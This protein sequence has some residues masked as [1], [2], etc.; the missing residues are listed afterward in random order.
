MVMAS[1][2]II[3]FMSR[4]FVYGTGHLER[5]IVQFVAFALLSFAAYFLVFERIRNES[6]DALRKSR[7]IYWIIF[8]SIACRFIYWPSQFIQ[9]TDPYRYVWDGQTVLRG[10]NPFQHSPEEA[11]NLKVVPAQQ[12]SNQGKQVF[13]RINHPG[14]KTIYPP[15]AQFIF[16]VSQWI[17]SWSV[18]GLK[19]LVLLSEINILF[20]LGLVLKEIKKPIEWLILYGWSPLVLKEFSNSLHV[21]TFVI[22]FLSLAAYF[23]LKEKSILSFTFLALATLVKYFAGFL[24]LPLWVYE[25]RRNKNRAIAGLSIYLGLLIIFY[26]PFLNAGASL[27]EG[28]GRFAA[29]WRVNEGI[30]GIIRAASHQLFY[31][32]LNLANE[33]ARIFAFL[34]LAILALFSTQWVRTQNASRA[35]VLSWMFILSALFFLSPAANPWYFTWIV[36]FFIFSPSRSLILF[37]G[38]VFLYY[39][40]LYFVYRGAAHQFVY[41]R[42]L[43]Y[44]L[45]FVFLGWELWPHHQ[46]RPQSGPIAMQSKETGGGVAKNKTV[47]IILPVSNERRL[48][49]SSIEHFL[50]LGADELIVVDGVSDDGTYETIRKAYLKVRLFQT[51]VKDRA[52]QM[53]LGAFESRSEVYLFVHADM[54]LPANAISL[55]RS[56][57]DNGANGGGFKKCY[58][59]RNW[60]LKAYCFISNLVF[61]YCAKSLVGT[62]AIFVTREAFETIGGFVQGSFME[63]VRFSECLKRIGRLSYFSEPVQVSP[64]RYEEKGILRQILKNS[65][66]MFRYKFLHQDPSSLREI[67]GV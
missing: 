46:F 27:F 57:V 37:S 32:D 24:L 13:E 6:Q 12:I 54:K 42:A 26:T 52:L 4:S 33:A 28:L 65:E 35:V 19:V 44:G 51:A 23:V 66:V 3:S 29:G 15:L 64:R 16:A 34:V 17:S 11:V 9:E 2:A 21:D 56:K 53:N 62:N 22:L 30:F 20:I 18:R 48:I 45:F 5:P 1:T 8:V 47:S 39:L 61:F 43:E 63:D 49:Q 31:Y 55:I 7:V 60:V 38:L 58:S 50:S 36:A 41:F 59:T 25:W 14:V 40:E 67:Y 10:G